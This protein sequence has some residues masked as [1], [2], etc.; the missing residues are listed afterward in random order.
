MADV[1]K[2]RGVACKTIDDTSAE[3]NNISQEIW[4]HPQQNFEEVFA[5]NLLT[6]FLKER[7]FEVTPKVAGLETAFRAEYNGDMKS[8]R[9][10]IICEY[11]ALPEID[12]ACGHNLIAEAGIAAALGIKA[13][14]EASNN[15]LGSLVVF[16]T[17]AEEGGGGKIFMIDEGCFDDVDFCMMVHPTAFDS[18]TPLVLACQ[19]MRIRYHGHAAHAA[20]FPWEG[21]NAL[22]AGV[23]CYTSL[24]MLRQQMKPTWRVH[25]V[26]KD[27]G[28]KPNI[29]PDTSVLKYYFRAPDNEE[30]VDLMAK[31]KGCW[32]GAASATGCTVEVECHGYGKN[33]VNYAAMKHNQVL[34]KLYQK[35][36][37]SL[38]VKFLPEGEAENALL[39]STDMGN[40]SLV[41]PSIHPAFTINSPAVI[42]THEFK[43][44]A[45]K[46]EAQA[47]VLIA[48]KS[49][50]MTSIDVLADTQLLKSVVEE[51][52]QK[53]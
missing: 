53:S 47:K 29:I 30:L 19:H 25:G 39:G 48:G 36:A 10:G 17:P 52:E 41:K 13:A 8:P 23:A 27:G 50:A 24:S 46:P 21:V 5:H 3:L 35:Y 33:N 43:D 49:M 1:S 16:G 45:S 4:K 9:V 32:E 28:V 42:H 44:A 20:A 11:D 26:F 38:G 18:A 15:T 12:H 31:A 40:V 2:L 34:A 7:G 37:E 6:T 51:F 14:I 22:D